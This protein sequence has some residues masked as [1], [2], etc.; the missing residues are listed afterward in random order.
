[1]PRRPIDAAQWIKNWKSGMDNAQAAY[2]RG[3]MQCAVDP[4]EEAIKKQDKMK[5]NLIRS[6]DDGSYAAGCRSVSKSQWQQQTS[7]VGGPRLSSG[8]TAALPKTTTKVNQMVI[9]MDQL[10]NQIYAMPNDTP[11]E[12]EQRQ[13]AWSRGMRALAGH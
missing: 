7:T 1:M 6:I 4:M 3:V 10:L 8:A 11:A 13:L 12:R 9:G 2:Q 5:A